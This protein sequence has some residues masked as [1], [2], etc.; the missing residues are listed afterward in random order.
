MT[1]N[2]TGDSIADVRHL[3]A[4]MIEY[5]ARQR[6]ISFSEQASTKLGFLIALIASMAG[7]NELSATDRSLHAESM[8]ELA[9]ALLV[10][11]DAFVGGWNLGIDLQMV[12]MDA[13]AKAG[14]LDPASLDALRDSSARL[15]LAP[16]A[17]QPV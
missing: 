5:L 11:D 14:A 7:A 15:S 9:R 13:H 6:S 1:K 8:F 2:S 10:T 4:D 12:V 16:P 3:T 17:S